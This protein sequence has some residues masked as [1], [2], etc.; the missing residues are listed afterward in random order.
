MPAIKHA[1]RA[2]PGRGRPDDQ[3]LHQRRAEAD[4]RQ[5]QAHGF[6]GPAVAEGGVEHEDRGQDLMGDIDQEIDSRQAVQLALRAQQPERAQRI[7]A[8]PGERH[9]AL[10]RQRF[11]QYEPAERG[12]DQARCGR[13]PERQARIEADQEAADRRPEHE[14][15][16]EGQADDAERLGPAVLRCYIGDVGEGGADRGRRD[17]GDDPADEQEGERG[18]PPP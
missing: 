9:A 2:E 8:L 10:R 1:P 7:G 12:V 14:A 11:G 3:A 13:H 4:E 18:A 17:A 6:L 16:A 15:Q 5:R